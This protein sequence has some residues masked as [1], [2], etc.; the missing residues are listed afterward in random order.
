VA[1]DLPERL[2]A[3]DVAPRAELSPKAVFEPVHGNDPAEW[4][5]RVTLSCGKQ[6]NIGSFDSENTARE[7]IVCKSLAWLKLMGC[8]GNRDNR[9]RHKDEA[10]AGG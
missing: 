9:I 5:V 7:W 8:D 1:Y 3:A 4:N 10:F 6:K 2:Q